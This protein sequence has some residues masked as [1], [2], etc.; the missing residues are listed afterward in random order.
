MP[1]TRNCLVSAAGLEPATRIIQGSH[2]T[3]CATHCLFLLTHF[4][5]YIIQRIK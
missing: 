4:I 2:A 1:P 5:R 3:N